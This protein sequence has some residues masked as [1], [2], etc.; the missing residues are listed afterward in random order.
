M[1]KLWGLN[2]R[3]KIKSSKPSYIQR[4]LWELQDFSNLLKRILLT[5]PFQAI[6]SDMTELVYGGGKAYLCVHKDAYGQLVYGY[7]LS[8]ST[9]TELALDSFNLA[10][11]TIRQMIGHIPEMICHQD[12]GSPY[13][14]YLYVDKIQKYMTLSYSKAGTPTDN[15][16]QESFFGRFKDVW[17]D[18]IAEI[19]TYEKLEEFVSEKIKYYNE[20]RF[21]TSIGRTKPMEFTKS[22]LNF[23]KNSSV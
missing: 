20:E 17:K 13:T 1:L 7:K 8:L 3:R 12:Q 14:S 16:G 18:E 21:H 15:P 9:N 6:T 2:L 5:E 19:P 10:V 11:E 4:T 22:F 23:A